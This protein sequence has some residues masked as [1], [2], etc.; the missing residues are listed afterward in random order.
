MKAPDASSGEHFP[1]LDGPRGP[2]FHEL[3]SGNILGCSSVTITMEDGMRTHFANLT[4][5]AWLLIVVPTVLIAY[6]VLGVIIP[7]VIHAVVPQV[8]RN[9]LHV[10]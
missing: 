9:V 2:Q 1:S 3:N 7:A 10:I 6:P 5:R 4:T 8:V